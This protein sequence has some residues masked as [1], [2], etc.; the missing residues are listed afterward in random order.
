MGTPGEVSII[1][2][3]LI[4][5]VNRYEEKNAGAVKSIDLSRHHSVNVQCFVPY[6]ISKENHFDE[7]PFSTMHETNLLE[8]KMPCNTPVLALM[9]DEPV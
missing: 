1:M 5:V 8:G 7:L 4:S 6:P 3:S 2:F 9:S